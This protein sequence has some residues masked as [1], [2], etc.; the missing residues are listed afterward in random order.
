[1]GNKKV[2]KLYALGLD[3]YKNNDLERALDHFNKALKLSPNNFKILSDKGAVLAKLKRYEQ[4]LEALNEALR[5]NPNLKNALTNKR[6]VLKRLGRT[7]IIKD[8]TRDILKKEK[9]KIPKSALKKS[10]AKEISDDESDICENCGAKVD[11]TTNICT[12]CGAFYN[13]IQK[14]F[15]QKVMQDQNLHSTWLIEAPSFKGMGMDKEIRYNDGLK[16][17]EKM[18]LKEA[19]QYYSTEIDKDQLNIINWNNYGVAFMGL[20]DRIHAAR[21]YT[22]ALK[23]DP[24]YYVSLYNLGAVYYECEQYEKAIQYF[25]KALRSNPHCG[26]AYWD[27]I[28]A[29]ERLGKLQFGATFKA[30]EMGIDTLR[31]KMNRNSALIDLG[32][33]YDAVLGSYQFFLQ[34][35]GKITAIYNDALELLKQGN[36]DQ[37]LQLLNQCIEINPEDPKVWMLKAEILYQKHR[38]EDSIACLDNVIKIN[39]N[40]FEGWLLKGTLYLLNNQKKEALYALEHALRIRPFQKEALDGKEAILKDKYISLRK[41]DKHHEAL[42]IIDNILAMNS[43]NS[44]D[45]WVDKGT[46]Y[47]EL[48][49]FEKAREC[50]T[51]ALRVDPRNFFAWRNRGALNLKEGNYIAAIECYN[52]A[53]KIKPDNDQAI[54]ERAIA[55]AKSREGKDYDKDIEK[56]KKSLN[57][58][59]KSAVDLLNKGADNTRAGKFEDALTCFNKALEIDPN[60]PE[61]WLHK[62]NLYIAQKDYAKAISCFNEVLKL[63][64]DLPLLLIDL[65]INKGVCHRKVGELEEAIKCYE[66]ASLIDPQIGDIYANLGN[67]YLDMRRPLE[68][69]QYFDKAIEVGSD[70]SA[71]SPT[72]KNSKGTA[73]L[74][75]GRLQEALDMYNEVMEFNPGYAPSWLG[76]GVVL[77]KLGKFKEAL[78]CLDKAAAIESDYTHAWYSKANL[79]YDMQEFQSALDCYKKV[80]QLDSNYLTLNELVRVKELRKK[81]NKKKGD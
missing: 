44:G 7:P 56:L 30:M 49:D 32:N 80:L 41:Q 21:C 25:D 39:A 72:A 27:K 2:D 3:Y 48:K 58:H 19:I 54:Q 46:V 43:P 52:E 62:A 53:L 66:Q 64:P 68:A 76:K 63:N 15:A 55:L 12:R 35:K 51:Q 60:F 24:D 42:K 57:S 73:F 38:L 71:F 33:G 70:Q 8:M 17:L 11:T 10:P 79:L 74:E 4:A 23:I 20:K 18:Q 47:G 22:Q 75:L 36:Q 16:H 28:L 14:A 34:Y 5:I 37:A 67:I 40:S 69:L 6:H 77:H 31:A 9:S 13:P 1:M 61:V 81:V 26:E 59:S 78:A 45:W 29:N 50:F 65:W